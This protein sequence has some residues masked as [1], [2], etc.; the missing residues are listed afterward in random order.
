MKA[1]CV[2]EFGGPEVLKLEGMPDPRHAPFRMLRQFSRQPDPT[3]TKL[4][5]AACF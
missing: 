2:S 3:W 5:V 1:I 4:C